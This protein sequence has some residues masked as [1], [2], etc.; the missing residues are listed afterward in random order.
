MKRLSQACIFCGDTRSV[1]FKR[2]PTRDVTDIVV[3]Q[4]NAGM[5]DPAITLLKNSIPPRELLQEPHGSS[6][7]PSQSTPEPE[8]SVE[9]CD[10]EAATPSNYVNCCICCF[11]WITRRQERPITL[12]PMQN[13]L[14]FMLA[15]TS[16]EDNK[17]DKRVLNRLTKSLGDEPDNVWRSIFSSHELEA[18]ECINNKRQKCL[19]DQDVFCVKRELAAFYHAQNGGSILLASSAITDL[20][21]STP[22]S[23]DAHLACN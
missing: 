11:H 7:L 15:V 16:A 5:S 12:L 14:Y 19:R 18:I 2:F 17:C 10:D 6:A 3:R 21:R 23:A 8:E 4:L 1:V 13:L 9:T 20:I 22:R